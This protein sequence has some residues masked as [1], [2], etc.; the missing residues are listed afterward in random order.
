MRKKRRT[1]RK[2]GAQPGVPRPWHIGNVVGR[3]LGHLFTGLCMYALLLLCSLAS[4]LLVHYLPRF[5][6]DRELIRFAGLMHTFLLWCDGLM[7]ACLVLYLVVRSL[8]ELP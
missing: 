1:R 6:D 5:S 8:K 2:E 4:S 3:F 7:F